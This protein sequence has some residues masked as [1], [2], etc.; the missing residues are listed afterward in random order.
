MRITYDPEGDV[1]YIEL[2]SADPVNSVD[3]EEGVTADLDAQGTII[4]LEILDARERLGE[5]SLS[6]I[7]YEHLLPQH[8]STSTASAA[9]SM[10]SRIVIE[11]VE[12]MF[13][14]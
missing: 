13:T 4:G 3:L 11:R 12:P 14:G 1:L 6:S 7:S 2:R 10:K 5:Q 8:G 9:R